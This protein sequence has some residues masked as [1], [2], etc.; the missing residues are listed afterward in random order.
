MK[1]YYLFYQIINLHD[2][3]IHLVCS[4]N[5]LKRD[6]FSYSSPHNKPKF[7]IPIIL[8]KPLS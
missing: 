2:L 4:Q 6:E 3:K 1:K 5:Q 7:K 8:S